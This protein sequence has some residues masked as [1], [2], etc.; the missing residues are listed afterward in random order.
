M[1]NK[2]RVATFNLWKDCGEFP[3]R[4]EKIA[5]YLKKV[6]CIC[7][8]ED[9]HSER[10]CSSDIINK[11][12]NLEKTTLSIRKK[13]RNGVLS[14][15]NLTIL[16][17]YKSTNIETLYFDKNGK[18]ERGALIVEFEI[19]EKRFLVLNTHLTNLDHRRRMEQIH[20]IQEC[21]NKKNADIFIVCGDMNS[22]PN[23]K[24]LQCI[25]KEGFSDFNHSATYEED[26]VLDYILSKAKFSYL[27]KSKILIEDLSDHYCLQNKFMW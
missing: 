23:S 21:I 19:D 15:S 6:D 16:S 17:K 22:V 18:D 5:P 2:F 27:V 7:F 4:I 8:Q 25:K 10:F 12:L 9:F 20:T 3:K 26:L 11:D 13:N 24:E 1:K 14:S